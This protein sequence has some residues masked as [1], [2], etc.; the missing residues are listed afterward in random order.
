MH[1]TFPLVMC[2][3]VFLYNWHPKLLLLLAFNRDEFFLRPTAPAHFWEQ[4]PHVLAG[5]DLLR[6]GTWLGITTNG[7]FSLLTNFRE[8]G[9]LQL[10]SDAP[11]R[12]DLPTDFLTGTQP[13]V[14]YL[15]GLSPGYGGFNLVVGDLA[16]DQVA[17]WSNRGQAGPQVLPPGA[18]GVS[19]GLLQQWPKV[20][21]TRDAVTQ[22]L[23]DHTHWQ[24]GGDLPWGQLFNVMSNT[25]KVD[26]PRQLPLT[27]VGKETDHYLSSAFVEQGDAFTAGHPYGTRSQT[28]MAVWRDGRMQLRERYVE[29]GETG[30]WM[31]RS[32]EHDTELHHDVLQAV[33]SRQREGAAQCP[34]TPIVGAIRESV[35]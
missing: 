19:N 26:D 2:L 16:A 25:T 6:G 33:D 18:Y 31:W 4:H 13:P 30:A 21:S 23:Q 32:T 10:T 35:C 17:Y 12:G 34:T 27:G 29:Q 7:R 11:S 20:H 24:D 5:R 9:G 8:G 22:L 1:T 3:S 14:E 28:L 15:Q